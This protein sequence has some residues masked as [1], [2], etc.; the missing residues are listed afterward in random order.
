MSAGDVGGKKG[1]RRIRRRPITENLN[2]FPAQDPKGYKTIHG[3][4]WGLRSAAAVT[5][6]CKH[7]RSPI[8]DAAEAFPLLIGQCL[9]VPIRYIRFNSYKNTTVQPYYRDRSLQI[10]C[11]LF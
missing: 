10:I 11:I 6:A 8:I 9:S 2:C 1:S 7:A 4:A 3:T 5:D